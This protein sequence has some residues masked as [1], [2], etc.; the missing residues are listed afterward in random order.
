MDDAL[1]AGQVGVVD[2]Q[3]AVLVPPGGAVV[4]AVARRGVLVRAV[5]AVVAP[6]GRGPGLARGRAVRVGAG[7]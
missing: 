2:R 7:V 5:G 4:V 6:V 1:A 3:V